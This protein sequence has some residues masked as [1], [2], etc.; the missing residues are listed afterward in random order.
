MY[1]YISASGEYKLDMR[2]VKDIHD[3]VQNAASQFLR[4]ELGW[5]LSDVADMLFVE[6]TLNDDNIVIE[7]RCELDYD[8]MI[9]MCAHLDPVVQSYNKESYFDMVDPGIAE[10]Y[11]YKL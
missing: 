8:D 5:S 2:L 4:E 1:K 9:E 7:V 11:I 3:D 10:A 6:P